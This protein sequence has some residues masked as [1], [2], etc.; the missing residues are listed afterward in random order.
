[1]LERDFQY[2]A[3]DKLRGI[4]LEER[5]RSLPHLVAH[6]RGF[7]DALDLGDKDVRREVLL[8]DDNACASPGISEGVSAR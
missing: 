5:L 6:L 4:R 1:M 7:Q 8:F 3:G 2:L